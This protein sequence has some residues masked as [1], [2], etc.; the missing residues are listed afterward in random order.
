LSWLQKKLS[1]HYDTEASVLHEVEVQA[2]AAKCQQLLRK[3]VEDSTAVC[4][5]VGVLVIVA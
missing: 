3:A 1:S 4:K 5:E 2:A